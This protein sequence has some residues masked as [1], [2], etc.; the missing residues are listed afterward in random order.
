MSNEFPFEVAFEPNPYLLILAASYGNAIGHGKHSCGVGMIRHRSDAFP[1]LYVPDSGSA[2]PRPAGHLL[3]DSLADTIDRSFMSLVDHERV[4]E[5]VHLEYLPVLP[6]REEP[7]TLHGG[8]CRVHEI[9]MIHNFL[10]KVIFACRIVKH[11][12]FA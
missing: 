12:E 11:E 3:R 5:K 1:G 6:A 9:L 2:V 8:S 4:P 7:I 10:V